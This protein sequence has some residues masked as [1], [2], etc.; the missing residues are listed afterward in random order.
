MES[1]GSLVVALLCLT[2]IIL[3][4]SPTP[5]KAFPLSRKMGALIGEERVEHFHRVGLYCCLGHLLFNVLP[6][7]FLSFH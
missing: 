7:L 5:P 1:L 3:E 4:F 6:E 2:R